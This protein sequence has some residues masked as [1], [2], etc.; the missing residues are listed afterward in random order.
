[1]ESINIDPALGNG[2]D[3]DLVFINIR[4]SLMIDFM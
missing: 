3:L 4:Q 2:L 1:M